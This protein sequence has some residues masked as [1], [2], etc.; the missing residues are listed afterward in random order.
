M[1]LQLYQKYTQAFVKKHHI[2]LILHKIKNYKEKMV[3][4]N[5]C[6]SIVI[7][8]LSATFQEKKLTLS[9]PRFHINY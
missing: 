5:K 9:G 4:Y 6:Q 2:I 8:I 3:F 7:S 1:K